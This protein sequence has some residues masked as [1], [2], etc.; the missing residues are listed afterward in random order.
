MGG[1]EQCSAECLLD[2]DIVL[3]SASAC[4]MEQVQLQSFASRI[5][6]KVS[7]IESF[8]IHHQHAYPELESAITSRCLP[9]VDNATSNEP[10]T[11]LGKVSF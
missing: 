9:P 11:E 4:R 8:K 2:G 10:C 1:T 3:R 7:L 5:Y 6:P